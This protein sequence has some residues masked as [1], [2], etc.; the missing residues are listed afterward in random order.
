MV[1][2]LKALIQEH[3]KFGPVSSREAAQKLIE[4]RP[5]LWDSVRAELAEERLSGIAALLLGRIARPPEDSPD[6]MRLPGL[7]HLPLLIPRGR[8]GLTAVAGARLHQVDAR[9]AALLRLLEKKEPVATRRRLKLR[10]DKIR[11]ELREW[12]KARKLMAYFAP[13]K[14]D[15]TV[16]EALVRQ[17]EYEEA[18]KRVGA[19]NAAKR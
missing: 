5:D 2:E 17:S 7:E 16:D 12:R 14:P 13:T 11:A 18:R 15:I 8:K 1:E 4:G 3:L 6:Q 9:I 19:A 10:R